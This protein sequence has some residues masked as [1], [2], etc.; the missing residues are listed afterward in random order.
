VNIRLLFPFFDPTVKDWS[1]T[2]RLVRW[3]T[4]LWLAIGL[5]VLF[6]AS[7]YHGEIDNKNGFFYFN[8]QIAGII[9]SLFIF[10]LIVH[11]PLRKILK[12]SRW[13]LF[14]IL[15]LLLL[16]LTGM[17]K[18]TYGASRWI[19]YGPIQIQPSELI[20]P[21]L[22][23]Q[24]ATLFGRWDRYSTKGKAIWLGIFALIL[25]AI[26]KQPNLSTTSL[27]AIGL[28]LI[29]FTAGLPLRYLTGTAIGAALV[30][31]LSIALNEYQQDR[32]SFLNPWA[33]QYRYGEGYQ[34]I[35]SLLAIGPGGLWG[36]GF[37]A[38]VQKLG[39]LK[40]QDTDFIFAVFAEEFGLVGGVL[41]LLMVMS[42]A[43]LGLV[44]ASRS[45]HPVNRLIAVGTTAF[46]VLQSFINIGVAVGTFPTTGVPL[47]MFSYGVTSVL[48][49]LIQSALLIRVARESSAAPV[50]QIRESGMG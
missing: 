29:A 28:W 41:L 1:L 49:S 40:F 26:L 30:A 10:N 47:P 13:I 27:C 44:I 37:G 50:V 43:T 46:I 12:I 21:F 19:G 24:G 6:S 23:L 42:Y 11:T 17:G 4:F 16:V 48:A 35:Q 8:R 20:K 32:L 34:L 45:R 9:G 5:F 36:K 15:L 14:G 2:A 22:V 25:L 33:P 7:Y 31:V 39:Y 38:S 18:T 3:L